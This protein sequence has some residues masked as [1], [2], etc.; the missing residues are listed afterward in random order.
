VLVEQ[1]LYK[2]QLNTP[3][4]ARSRRQVALSPGTLD[5][6]AQWRGLRTDDSDDS[7][8]FP[9]ERGTPYWR[10]NMWRQRLLPRLEKVGLEWA[11][12]QVMRRTHAS[13]SRMAGIDPKL[14]ADQLGHGIGVNLDT[15]TV[16]GL[17]QRLAAVNALEVCVSS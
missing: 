7:W 6:L 14:V 17:P 1:R 8:V 9:T 15:Y 3:K 2:G 4:T 16:A 11:N 12:F 5:T 13:L 10:D